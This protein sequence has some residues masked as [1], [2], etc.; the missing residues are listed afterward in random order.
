MSE[1]K[2]DGKNRDALIKILAEVNKLIIHFMSQ[3]DKKMFY[4][5]KQ[6]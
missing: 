3:S 5:R 6:I 1:R 4:L 2:R